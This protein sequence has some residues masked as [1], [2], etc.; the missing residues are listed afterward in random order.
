MNKKLIFTGF[1]I[2]ISLIFLMAP[3]GAAS[4][5]ISAATTT[6]TNY[7]PNP[8]LNT[9]VSWSTF[10]SSMSYNQYLNST[11]GINYLNVQN[12][13]GNFI[14]LNPSDIQSKDL[15]KDN[16]SKGP[17]W[18]TNI[19]SCAPPG[20]DIATTYGVSGN[21][22]YYTAGENTTN[23]ASGYIYYEIPTS[24]LPS[25]NPA[26]DYITI[27]YSLAGTDQTG[28]SGSINIQNSSNNAYTIQSI[29]PG[30]SG[31][32]SISLEQ[33][34][35]ESG[36]RATFNTTGSGA[37]NYVKIRGMIGTPA[38]TTDNI[39]NLSIE[40][41]ALTTYSM[42]LGSNS[43]GAHI[44]Q[45]IGNIYLADFNPAVPMTIST[46]GYSE[47]LTQPMS[48]TN[49][50]VTQTPLTSGN[51]IEQVGYQATFSL[52]SSPD[53]SYSASNFSLPLSVP[54]SQFQVL[55][56]NGVSYVSSLGN[57]TNGTAVLLSSVNPTSTISYLA[58][59]DYTATQWQSI[60]H[61]AG[62]F[63]VDGIEY[64]WFIVV[65]AIAGLLGLAGGVRHAHNKADQREEVKGMGP[66]V[67]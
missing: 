63:T 65:G 11:G 30:Q 66:K 1:A 10:N 64:Y 37:T 35:K 39:Y 20:Y 25:N 18:D 49:Y 14:A 31:Y 52:P 44:N 58:Y 45:G 33:I 60:S 21:N 12:G 59:V 56:V 16:L 29:T 5:S 28:V 34:E 24:D 15:Q 53:L 27:I 32:I 23:G 61:P 41:M 42:T 4:H 43:T 26:Y 40:G 17:V 7:Q 13:S 36:Y 22:V 38:S 57:K 51:Y 62:I 46:N 3:I 19:W 8:S 9:Q 50:S 67:R 48:L 47:N 6:S 2:F 54:A 55:E